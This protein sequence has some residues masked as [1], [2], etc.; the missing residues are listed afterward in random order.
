MR[1]RHVKG[2]LR[3]YLI[4]YLDSSRN[5]YPQK[6]KKGHNLIVNDNNSEIA[7]AVTRYNTLYLIKLG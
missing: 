3:P 2:T 6:N 7:I 1:L 5:I 4:W